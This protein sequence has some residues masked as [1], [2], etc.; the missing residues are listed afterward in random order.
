MSWIDFRAAYRCHR[1][2]RIP[3]LRSLR[4]AWVIAHPKYR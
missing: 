1:A 2:H 3:V 4:A